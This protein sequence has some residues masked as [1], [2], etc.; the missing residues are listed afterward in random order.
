M[1]VRS[2]MLAAAILSVGLGIS[3]PV[4]ADPCGALLCLAGLASGGDGGPACEL[5]VVDYFSIVIFDPFGGVDLPATATARQEFL[6]Q[7]PAPVDADW[8]LL[9][10]SAFGTMLLPPSF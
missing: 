2:V 3:L 6:A 10:N 7:C 1:T 8:M 9:A 5:H 4:S